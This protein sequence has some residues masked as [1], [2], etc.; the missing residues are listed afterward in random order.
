MPNIAQFKI[1]IKITSATKEELS[2]LS[3]LERKA[4][5]SNDFLRIIK[6]PPEFK[7]K[8]R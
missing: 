8:K 1:L 2:Y 7:K 3:L 5:K 4:S 6:V